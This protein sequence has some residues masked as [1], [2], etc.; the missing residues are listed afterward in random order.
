[1]LRNAHDFVGNRIID[2]VLVGIQHARMCHERCI[3]IAVAARELLVPF[4][5][6]C[7]AFFPAHLFDPAQFVQLVGINSVPQIIKLAIRHKRDPLV[8]LVILVENLEQRA[9][10]FNIGHF[11]LA[12]NIV[13]VTRHTLVHDNVKRRGNIAHVEKVARVAAITVNGQWNVTDSLINKLWN[14]LFRKLMR[15]INIVAA[16]NETRELEGAKVGLDQEFGTSLGSRVRIRRL[17]NVLFQHWIRLKALAFAVHFIRRHVHKATQRAAHFGRFEQ[18]MRAVNVGL[19]KG[20]GITERVVDMCLCR[21]VQNGIN[22]FLAQHV[23]DE[24]GRGNVSLDKL[25]IRQV[26][27]LFQVG[28]ARAVVEAVVDD[29]VVIRILFA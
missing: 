5:R 14:E 2:I 21:K 27:Q 1:V 23:A 29:N 4:N 15:S 6:R 18:N 7:Q 11:I 3:N 22:L 20:K 9:R 16:R 19:R 8:L 17:Q 13:N 28:Q 25:E 24:I 12:A 10:H 26:E